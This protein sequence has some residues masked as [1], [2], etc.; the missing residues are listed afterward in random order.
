MFLI[1]I[2]WKVGLKNMFEGIRVVKVN[3]IKVF[4]G[5][6]IVKEV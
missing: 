3:R 2:I 5:F 4:K 6:S 1:R